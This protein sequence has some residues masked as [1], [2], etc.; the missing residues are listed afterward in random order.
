MNFTRFFRC[1]GFGFMVVWLGGPTVGSAAKAPVLRYSGAA[2]TNAYSYLVEVRGETGTEALAGRLIVSSRTISSNVI[3]LTFRGSLQPKRDL[4]SGNFYSG[5]SRWMSPVMFNEACEV[6]MDPRGKVLRLSGDFPLPL[7]VGS[8]AQSFIASLPA[9][10][11]TKWEQVEEVAVL[12]E[13]LGL[14]P[15]KGFGMPGPAGSSMYYYTPGSTRGMSAVVWATRRSKCEIKTNTTESATVQERFA[16]DSP[17]L[18]GTEPR[19][20][21]SGEGLWVFDRNGGFLRSSDFQFQA[22]LNSDSATRRTTLKLKI[23]L[24]EGKERDTALLTLA[25]R[26]SIDPNTGRPVSNKM[27]AEDLAKAVDDLQS[28]DDVKRQT[29]A[30]RIQGAELTAVSPAVLDV[31]SNLLTSSEMMVRY[32]AVKVIADF[33]TSEYVPALLRVLKSQDSSGRHAAIRGLGRLKDARAIEPLVALIAAGGS[34]SYSASSALNSF[35]AEA[36]DAVLALLKEKHIETR[37]TACNI[38]QKIGTSKSIEPLKELTTHPDSMLSS[39]AAEA[40]RS[41]MARQ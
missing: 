12:D 20:S 34:D 16:V 19:V 38:L 35:G 24:L 10:N 14:G 33:G 28:S 9:G 30:S 1:L 36:E 21:A 2:Q 37:R 11:E 26:P 31:M 23:Q 7:P 25:G 41:I 3:G 22:L 18:V 40:I 17:L 32:A 13:P 5:R 4:S 27:S 29:A 39:A 15:T 8:V 6:Q